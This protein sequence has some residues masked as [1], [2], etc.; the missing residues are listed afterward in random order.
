L[1]NALKETNFDGV[2]AIETDSPIFAR[3]PDNF[4]KSAKAYYESLVNP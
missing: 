2:L 4:V 3:Q 1:V